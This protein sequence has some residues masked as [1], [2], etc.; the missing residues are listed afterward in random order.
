MA[1][2]FQPV[3]VGGEATEKHLGW[4]LKHIA[5]A[6]SKAAFHVGV[7]SGFMHLALLYVPYHRTHLYNEAGGY[8]SH[9]AKRARDNG[10]IINLHL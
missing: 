1:D 9:H 5:Y 3:V 7:D 2:G 6:M 8:I 10:A 4:S